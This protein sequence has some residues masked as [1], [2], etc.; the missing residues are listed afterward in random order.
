MLN[1]W[2]DLGSTRIYNCVLSPVVLRKVPFA[3]A[4]K[5][6]LK[7]VNR[8]LSYHLHSHR[9][10]KTDK[11]SINLSVF[12]GPWCRRLSGPK[13]IKQH[14]HPQDGLR[15]VSDGWC[16]CRLPSMNYVAEEQFTTAIVDEEVTQ[17][18]MATAAV[19]SPCYSQF[20][21]QPKH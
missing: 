19:S 17:S 4:I 16:S 11:P 3:G 5:C 8:V 10:T 1:C 14:C 7:I 13:P 9:G 20:Q 18:R 15:F 12:K 2:I 6:W 21:Q